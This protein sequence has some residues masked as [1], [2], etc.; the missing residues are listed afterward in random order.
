VQR[1]HNVSTGN[2]G[3]QHTYANALNWSCNVGM[4]NIIQK[5]GQALFDKYIRDFGFGAKSNLTIDGE[6]FS[7]IAPYDR[8]SRLQFFTMS[9][10]QGISVNMVQMAAAYAVLANG[11]VYMQP[12]IVESMTYPNGK[13]IDTIPTP[14]RRVIKEDTS[15]TIT[16]M[17]VDGA[18]YGY[19]VSGN[20]PGYTIAGKT[21][22]SQIPYRGTYENVYF[23]K[24]VGHTTTSYGGYAPAY[25]P[26]FVMIVRLERPR[27]AVYAETTASA[28]WG[29]IAKYLL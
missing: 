18:K 12:Y 2:C 10:G 9:F 15:K 28:A 7:Q 21:G 3:G 6:V 16:A 23:G 25:N 8:W 29:E 5:I 22:T 14:I 26:K 17:L 13:K 27:T 24:D 1:I 11:G 20:V 4:V 19:A